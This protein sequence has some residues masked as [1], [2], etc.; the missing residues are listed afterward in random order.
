MLYNSSKETGIM[1]DH[2][3]VRILLVTDEFKE[4]LQA[5]PLGSDAYRLENSPWFAYGVSFQDVVEA[6]PAQPDEAGLPTFVRVLEKS[7]NR[8]LRVYLEEPVETELEAR[9]HP[10]LSTLLDLGCSVEGTNGNYFAVNVPA[11][12]DFDT[13]CSFLYSTSDLWE[14]ADPTYAQLFPLEARMNSS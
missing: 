12:A 1:S 9:L 2:A 6:R 13:V 3:L 5:R 11:E 4:S 7:G 8:T 10:T 14:Y